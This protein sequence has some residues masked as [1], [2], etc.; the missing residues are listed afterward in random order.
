[1]TRRLFLSSRE[2][3]LYER[4]VDRHYLKMPSARSTV[5][6]D[7]WLMDSMNFIVP[8]PRVF[9]IGFTRDLCQPQNVIKVQI[10]L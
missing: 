8:F 1:M 4:L 7:S 5:D 3:T 6:T 2:L 10:A 9:F